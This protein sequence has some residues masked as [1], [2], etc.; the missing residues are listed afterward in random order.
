LTELDISNNEISEIIP[1]TFQNMNS[2][3]YLDLM[4]NRLQYLDCAV[5]SVLVNLELT[6]YWKALLIHSQCTFRC[7][8]AASKLSF[9]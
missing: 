4:N 6:I 7:T 1:G 8:L 9:L 5:F 3:E 2:L